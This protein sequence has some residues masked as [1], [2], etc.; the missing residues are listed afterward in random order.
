MRHCSGFFRRNGLAHAAILLALLAGP[1]LSQAQAILANDIVEPRSFG[2]AVGDEIRREVR[3]SV[4]S[5][6]RLDV[7]S[8]PKAGR[9]DRWLELAAPEVRAESISNGQRYHIV[10]TYQ[11]FNAP[12]APEPVAIVT[13]PQ[14]NLRILG[15]AEPL[16]ALV[17]ALRVSVAPITSALGTDRLSGSSLQQDRP[18]APLPVQARQ[19]RLAWT[20]AALTALL[21]FAAWR[22]GLRAFI[23]R[24]NLPFARAVREL[25][26]SEPASG[27][28]AHPAARL[29]IVHEA[30]NRTAGRAVFA[31]NLDDFLAA[32]PAYAG[33]RNEFAR[34]FT[35]SGRVFFTNTAAAEPSGSDSAALLRL[36]RSCRKIE[37][38]LQRPSFEAQAARSSGKLNEPGD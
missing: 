16:T 38:R 2:Y 34:L 35:A 28:P 1:R 9:L 36:C 26:R 24:G 7:A 12:L 23:A 11:I 19:T 21:L 32:H 14:Q 33:L 10:L 30:V 15:D 22:R 31:H 29:K 8:L 20:G 18:P 6:Y 4:R 27:A 13:L 5:G 17:P 37:R 25:K 3:L